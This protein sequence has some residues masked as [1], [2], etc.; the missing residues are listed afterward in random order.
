M[1]RFDADSSCHVEP[2]E[3]ILGGKLYTVPAITLPVWQRAQ[4]A[5]TKGEQFNGIALLS[6]IL[7]E[8]PEVLEALPAQQILATSNFIIREF[9][10]GLPLPEKNGSGPERDASEQSP[11]PGQDS[12]TPAD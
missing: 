2:L 11:A 1:P 4:Q 5:A 3:I 6:E 12:T 10:K 8:R 7:P 9:N